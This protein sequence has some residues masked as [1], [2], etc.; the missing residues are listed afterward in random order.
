MVKLSFAVISPRRSKIFG[1]AP[2]LLLVNFWGLADGLDLIDEIKLDAGLMQPQP[3]PALARLELR[4]VAIAS[5]PT[6]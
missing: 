4:Q 1:L 2:G 5:C 3:E 6:K